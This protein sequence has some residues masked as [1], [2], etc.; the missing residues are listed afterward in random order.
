[1]GYYR[2]IK[3][4]TGYQAQVRAWSWGSYKERY[5]RPTW[6]LKRVGYH[7]R[8]IAN[9]SDSFYL[10]DDGYSYVTTDAARFACEAYARLTARK[11]KQRS[12]VGKIMWRGRIEVEA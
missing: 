2:V 7:W 5:E 9:Q 1:M 6:K 11:V 12:E 3:S 4:E 10:R 8:N